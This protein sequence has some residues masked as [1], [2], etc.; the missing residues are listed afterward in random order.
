MKEPLRF[1]ELRSE[2]QIQAARKRL[3]SRRKRAFKPRQTAEQRRELVLAFID[4][5]PIES[6]VDKYD[7]TEAG[8]RYTIRVGLARDRWV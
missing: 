5:A 2:E 6:L 7:L 4:G 3:F 8:V 1:S